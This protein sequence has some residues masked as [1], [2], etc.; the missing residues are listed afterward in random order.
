MS[1]DG[2]ESEIELGISPASSAG[3]SL[4]SGSSKIDLVMVGEDMT[5][6]GDGT[7][8]VEKRDKM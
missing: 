6:S 5:T 4:R 7:A 1:S 2:S 8:M 3:A